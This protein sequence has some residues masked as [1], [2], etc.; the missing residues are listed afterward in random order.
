MFTT[1]QM[2]I[3]TVNLLCCLQL[4]GD[5]EMELACVMNRLLQV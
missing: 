4:I 5:V 2:N 3:A 1:R